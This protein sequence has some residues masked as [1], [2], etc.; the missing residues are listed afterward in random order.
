F[1]KLHL[2]RSLAA[3]LSVFLMLAALGGLTYYGLNQASNLLE[4]LP[5]YAGT[6]RQDVAKLSRKTHNLDVLNP[7]GEKGT[8][9]VHETTSVTDLMSRGFGSA[10]EV[11]LA[12][13]FI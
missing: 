2:P 8:V 1:V 7:A 9:R 5:K 12:A 6:I 13:S 4:Q 10:T 11:V 3:G